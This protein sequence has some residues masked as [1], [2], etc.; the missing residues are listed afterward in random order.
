MR[1]EVLL[2]IADAVIET[3]EAR[4]DTGYSPAFEGS[5]R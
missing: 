1:V 5:F 2:A 3:H 4:A